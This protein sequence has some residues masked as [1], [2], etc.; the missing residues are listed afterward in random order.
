MK[1]LNSQFSILNFPSS[2]VFLLI[3][4]ALLLLLAPLLSG[5]IKNWK[6]RRKIAGARAFGSRMPT[7][8]SFSAR[9]W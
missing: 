4:A 7:S 5:C 9:T 3:Q 6:A 8:L 2:C 1:T